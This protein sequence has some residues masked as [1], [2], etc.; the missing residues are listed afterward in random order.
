MFCTDFGGWGESTLKLFLK[1]NQYLGNRTTYEYL[2]CFSTKY[3]SPSSKKHFHFEKSNE[4]SLL[5]GLS[6]TLQ[7]RRFERSLFTLRDRDSLK[8]SFMVNRGYLLC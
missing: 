7:N 3:K 2:V 1:I 5:Y 6:R 4:K 8:R